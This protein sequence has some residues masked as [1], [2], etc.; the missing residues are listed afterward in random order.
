MTLL[1]NLATGQIPMDNIVFILM[2]ERAKFQNCKNTVCMRYRK[3]TKVF[4]SIVYRLCKGAGLKFFS[5]EKNWG[6]VVAKEC[7]RS[8]YNP[9]RSKI[10]FAVPS[11]RVLRHF[12]AQLPKIIPPGKIHRCLDLLKGQK[13]IILMADG[14][15][16]TKGLKENFCG[17]VNLFG[18][19]TNPN[20]A[21]LREEIQRHLNFV[22]QSLVNFNICDE[23]DKYGLL[24]DFTNCITGLTGKIRKFVSNEQTCLLS[25]TKSVFSEQKYVKVISSCKTNIY[26]SFL[27]LKKALQLN[28]K[29]LN[30]MSTI[31]RNNHIFASSTQKH[32]SECYNIRLLHSAEYVLSKVDPIDYPHLIKDGSEMFLDLKRQ[33]LITC[34]TVYNSL[35]LYTSKAMKLHFRQYV[36][37][38]ADPENNASEHYAGISTLVHIIM[39]SFLPSCAVLY[40]EGCRFLDGKV[41][42]KLMCS[43]K[44]WIIRHHHTTKEKFLKCNTSL[45]NDYNNIV[46]ISKQID[47][48][49]LQHTISKCEALRVLTTMRIVNCLKCW[50]LSVSETSIAVIEA[51]FQ[52]S[53][54]SSVWKK[55]ATYYDNDKPTCP[56]KIGQLKNEMYPILDDYI[57]TNTAFILEIPRLKDIHGCTR[58][59]D[60]FSAYNIPLVP[61]RSENTVM[62]DNDFQGICCDAADII[63]EGYNFLRVEASE[64]LAFVATNCSRIVQPGLPPHLPI[65]YG[66]RGHS[67]PMDIMRNMVNDIRNELKKREASVLCEVYDGQFHKLNVR[68]QSGQPLTRLQQRHD[69]FN[70][71]MKDYERLELIERLSAYCKISTKDLEYICN[72]EFENNIKL[73]LDTVT[74]CFQKY[75]VQVEDEVHKF[76]QIFIEC[77][78]VAG[79][80]MKDIVTHPNKN[81]WSSY[82]RRY[83]YGGEGTKKNQLL[84]NDEMQKLI[85]GSK[86]RRRST[87][88]T[89]ELTDDEDSD[90]EDPDYI[91][92]DSDSDEGSENSDLDISEVEEST[93]TNVTVA[94]T[95]QSCIKRILRSLQQYDNKHNWRSESVDSFLKKYLSNKLCVSKLF[96]YEMDT[97][98]AEVVQS[99]G[100]EL[101]KKSDPKAVQT[102][103]IC[104]QLKKIPQLFEY[105]SSEEETDVIQ[106]DTLVVIVQKLVLS[107]KYPKEFL[108]AP[109][110][111]F[112]HDEA[113][114]KWESK[115]TVP[116]KMCLPFQHKEH[117]IFNYPEFSED[118]QQ[119]EMRTFDYTHILNNLR[120]HISNTGFNNVRSRAF[121]RVS[122]ID[123]DV[124]PRAIV[125]LKM[126]RQ[127]CTISQRFF[128]E[129]VQRI[130]TDLNFH[131][132]AK[133]VQLVRMWFKACDERG[134]DVNERLMNLTHMYDYL[135]SLLEF[136][137]YPPNKTH[138]SGIPIR[139]YEALLHCISTRFS[140]FQLSSRRCYN[141]RAIST[142]A[143]ESFFSDLTR[144]EFSGLGAPKSV[145]IPKLI[146]HIVHINSAKHDPN[147]GFEFTTSTR[148]NYPCYMLQSSDRCTEPNDYGSHPFDQCNSNTKAKKK[149]LYIL[150]K[151]KQITKGG[152]GIW[153]YMKID[154]TKLTAEQR[155]GKELNLSEVAI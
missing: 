31:Q 30:L 109:M 123:H 65:A 89:Y 71:I 11:E 150:G 141:T 96:L 51:T 50:Y 36:Q 2:L 149:K 29:L 40:E 138:I 154:E 121:L 85:T 27:W 47:D 99:F 48:C 93:L 49:N 102:D 53:A 44:H 10:N 122:D 69:H 43:S 79:Y 62:I 100:K 45:N 25:Y 70:G 111:E 8:H 155:Y 38:I 107:R 42:K 151:P 86:Y 126:D 24:R 129:D 118:R 17:D 84:T 119:I 143:V 54:W 90:G 137:H 117:V 12:D 131:Q 140:L 21:E 101:F 132:E 127:N 52:K 81:I 104:K 105:S 120:F 15:L 98:N 33:S 113:V 82:R 94:S 114:C 106:P 148:D 39:P 153:Q 66:L 145:D 97:I 139:T 32:L 108:A 152:H 20:I 73:K 13:D 7:Q 46:V 1:R 72:A 133:F 22:S 59:T 77:N 74:M 16:V 147:R 130:L 34:E 92:S 23:V 35:G 83:T 75:E 103:K 110:A 9:N 142:L 57:E 60:K 136:S 5:G 88:R 76:N 56:T 80:S 134:M 68:S 67:M 61:T 95:G 4:W 58:T 19:E 63:E 28:V 125:E 3:V 18:H 26:T 78:P 116:I 144:F 146:S 91:P 115:S 41:K 55:I 135:V 6:Q 124:L 37:E 112:T 87:Y 14:K 64:I 128:S